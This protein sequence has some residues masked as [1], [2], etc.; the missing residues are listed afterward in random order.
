M[1]CPLDQWD[2]GTFLLVQWLGDHGSCVQRFHRRLLRMRMTEAVAAALA[3]MGMPN[4]RQ[5][6]I[7]AKIK[8]MTHMDLSPL[9]HAT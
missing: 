7:G 6:S 8:G 2:W 1:G 5:Y 9:Q 4:F 3:A